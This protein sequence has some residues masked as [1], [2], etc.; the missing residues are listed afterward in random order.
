MKKNLSSKFEEKGIIRYMLFNSIFISCYISNLI[1][2]IFENY[3]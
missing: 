1:I 2:N 3:K